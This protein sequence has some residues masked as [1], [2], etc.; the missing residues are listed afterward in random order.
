M[1]MGE[2]G[3][4]ICPEDADVVKLI[5]AVGV[6]PPEGQAMIYNLEFLGGTEISFKINN[7]FESNAD[8]YVQYDENV[9]SGL[10]IMDPK[11]AEDLDVPGCNPDNASTITAG[12]H[13]PPGKAAFTIVSIYFVSNDSYLGS[14][15]ATVDECCHEDPD[16]I[17]TPVVEY[18]FEI[19]CECPAT[20]DAARNL[21]G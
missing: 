20:S 14:G 16:T 3:D 1:V 4:T 6:S 13:T 15:G 9:G 21:R 19:H 7:P 17:A 2:T 10:G 18:T 11:C 5:S 8:V 12:C